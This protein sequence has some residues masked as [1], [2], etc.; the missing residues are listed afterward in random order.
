MYFKSQVFDRIKSQCLQERQ[1]FVD[2]EFSSNTALGV[3][4][5]IDSEPEKICHKDS[6]DA[7]KEEALKSEENKS[8]TS[9]VKRVH[10]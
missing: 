4:D 7:N 10:R 3:G 5:I 1:L 9:S 6:E 2:P 8:I